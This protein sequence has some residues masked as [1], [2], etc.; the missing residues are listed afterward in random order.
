MRNVP[1]RL[2]SLASGWRVT[3]PARDPRF[4]RLPPG[5]ARTCEPRVPRDIRTMTTAAHGSRPADRARRRAPRRDHGGAEHAPAFD[6]AHADTRDRI[7]TG[8][9]SPPPRPRTASGTPCIGGACPEP[10]PG[11][12]VQR[13]RWI[14]IP[15]PPPARSRGRVDHDPAAKWIPV[16]PP[17]KPRRSI[18][19][20]GRVRSSSSRAGSSTTCVPIAAVARESASRRTSRWSWRSLSQPPPQPRFAM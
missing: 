19:R 20:R 3:A 9:R 12:H 4:R 10:A 15:P 1:A 5:M 13:P 2:A 14:T 11:S 7:R 17:L 18:S 6:L 8:S 16:S